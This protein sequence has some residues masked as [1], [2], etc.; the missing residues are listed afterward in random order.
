MHDITRL[1]LTWY[2]THK[3]DLPWR[4]TRDPYRIWISEVILQQTRVAQ[5]C[6]YF[7]RFISRFPTVETLA[8]ASEDEVMRLWQGLGYYSRA[9]N[10]HTAARQI[11]AMDGFP[12]TYDTIRPLMGVGDY[13]AAAIASFAFDEPVAAVDGNVC[14][15]WSRVMGIDAPIDTAA[16]KR[17]IS[18]IAQAL[19]PTDRAAM[20]NQAAMEF[21]ALQCVPANPRCEECPLAHKCMALA[22]GRVGQ[23][24]VKA[25]KTKVT[26]RYFHYLYI[27]NGRELLLRKRP[28]GDIWQDLYEF[29][30]IETAVAMDADTLMNT[31]EW[32]TWH[33]STPYYIY[34]GC[35]EGVRHVLSHRVLHTSF[36]ELEVQGSLP[37]PEGYCCISFTELDRY[38]LPRL[39]ERYLEG[40]HRNV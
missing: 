37:C 24:P 29:P 17:Q 4:S 25:H 5:G 9:R 18:E 28:A 7:V 2:D 1:L 21:G 31:S 35:V 10:L 34:R 23:L 20:Y 12:T 13:T 39:I 16:G 14:R 15:V 22:E 30:L 38:A 19:L 40:K 8:Q 36:Y 32:A 33:E 27:H 11:V 6:D 3:R 26:S